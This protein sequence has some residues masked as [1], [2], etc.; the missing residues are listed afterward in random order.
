[1]EAIAAAG[2]AMARHARLQ[3]AQPEDL[4]IYKTVPG[5]LK[6]SKTWSACSSLHGRGW[7]SRAFA[8]MFEI[9]VRRWKRI[10]SVELDALILRVAR[11]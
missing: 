4:V 5:A 2:P 7:I 1:M 11:R 9:S 3:V 10:A 8:G 6:I